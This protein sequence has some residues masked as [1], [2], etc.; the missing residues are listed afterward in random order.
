MKMKQLLKRFL[1]IFGIN[2][3][4]MSKIQ[5]LENNS[6]RIGSI[7]YKI[8]VIEGVSCESKISDNKRKAGLDIITHSTVKFVSYE[9]KLDRD[10]DFKMMELIM[11]GKAHF[12]L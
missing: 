5:L 11:T 2:I 6:F 4:P 9:D 3:F 12:Q 1:S 8:D 7:I 10:E